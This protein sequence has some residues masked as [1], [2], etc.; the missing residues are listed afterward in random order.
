MHFSRLAFTVDVHSWRFAICY[1][2]WICLMHILKLRR[3]VKNPTPSVDVHLHEEQ[4][5]QISFRSDLKRQSL[6]LF[7]ED[8]PNNKNNKKMM[9]TDIGSV[10][11]PKTEWL[12]HSG[13]HCRTS[14][15]MDI[16]GYHKNRATKADQK[17]ILILPS[18][19]PTE[20][21][22]AELT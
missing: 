5:R 20:G 21:K 19:R 18:H 16:T 14:T 7:K 15:T 9:R 13:L 11:E 12:D 22:K 1:M 8:C 3:N 10:A 17:L 2:L 4:S 6:R